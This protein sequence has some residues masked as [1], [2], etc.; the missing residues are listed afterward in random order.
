MGK[1]LRVAVVSRHQL[2]RAG[3]T[4]LIEVD[5]QR[6]RVV[7]RASADGH[8][9]H[10][11]VAVYDLAGLIATDEND[12]R[13]LIASNT[14]VVALQPDARTDVAEG[15]LAMGVADVVQMN[16][17]SDELLTRLERAVD[18]RRVTPEQA[19]EQAR[20]TARAAAGLT[21]REI[22]VLELVGAGLSNQQIAEHLFVSLNTVKTYIRSAY[23]RIG[24]A[25]RSQAVIWVV[26][27]GLAGHPPA[28]RSGPPESAVPSD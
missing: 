14:A 6:A 5:P 4:Q 18:G 15:A 13:H 25:R 12:L 28:T 16:V 2:T 19:R 11:D 24:A 7:D 22:A 17:T 8:L 10:H 27:Q 9:G 21:E 20:E 26:Q 23:K 3:L 1:P